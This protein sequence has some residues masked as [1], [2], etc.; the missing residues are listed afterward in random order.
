MVLWILVISGYLTGEY[1]LHNRAKAG[2]VIFFNDTV[3][4]WNA[5][6]SIVGLFSVENWMFQDYPYEADQWI[7][8]V[9]DGLEFRLRVETEQNRIN[10]NTASEAQVRNRVQK[11]YGE[12]FFDEGSD[13][14]DALL[15]WR[16]KDALV[17]NGGAEAEYYSDLSPGY[18]PANGYFKALTELLLVKG[19]AVKRFWGDYSDGPVDQSGNEIQPKTSFIDEFTIFP[20]TTRRITV[21]FPVGQNREML[22]I[23]FME[24]RQSNRYVKVEK[25][26]TFLTPVDKEDKLDF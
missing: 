23:I 5:I 7:H 26:T 14:P 19:V 12:E 24:K 16:D 17:R 1:L 15:D 25:Y 9:F 13:V 2:S 18:E 11:I 21:V 22:L 3:R 6:D 8:L 4:R 20:K 10:I